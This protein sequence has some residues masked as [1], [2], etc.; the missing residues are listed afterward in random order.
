MLSEKREDDVEQLLVMP[1]I[2]RVIAIRNG[3]EA[4]KFNGQGVPLDL[5]TLQ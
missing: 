4:G 1:F 3:G 2:I 5:G